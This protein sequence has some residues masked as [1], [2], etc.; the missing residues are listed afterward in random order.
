MAEL[1]VQARG[2]GVTLM[3]LKDAR[4]ADLR[5]FDLRPGAE[6]ERQ[7]QGAAGRRPCRLARRCAAASGRMVPNG[8][9]RNN[10]FS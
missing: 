4:L 2:K 6:L 3:R 5:T 8:F 7:R 1:P 9:P 10:R